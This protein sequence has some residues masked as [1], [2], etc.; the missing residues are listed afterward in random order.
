M[1]MQHKASFIL[2][3]ISLDSSLF[4]AF[5][6]HA[7]YSYLIVLSGTL[8]LDLIYVIIPSSFSSFHFVIHYSAI[9]SIHLA[10]EKKLLITYNLVFLRLPFLIF[11]D[12]YG[13]R[14]AGLLFFTKSVLFNY[15]GI[16][17]H[18]KTKSKK[19]RRNWR[20]G[21]TK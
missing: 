17:K 9:F 7:T 8:L 19:E 5:S 11:C 13:L 14:N 3:A 18:R 2:F 4:S 16:A 1:Q 20:I 12:C 10:V 21:P 15:L 6:F